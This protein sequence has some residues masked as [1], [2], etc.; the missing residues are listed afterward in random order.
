MEPNETEKTEHLQSRIGDQQST[1]KRA[2]DQTKTQI[3]VRRQLTIPFT[4]RNAEYTKLI[5]AYWSAKSVGVQVVILSGTTGVGKTR[6]AQ[7]FLAWGIVQ[8][9]YVLQS[10]AHEAT[11]Q[12]L[13]PLTNIFNQ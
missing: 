8:S 10:T 11:S 4:G 6:L 7:Q 13:Q 5:N 2:S 3:P 9:I 12:H 1:A